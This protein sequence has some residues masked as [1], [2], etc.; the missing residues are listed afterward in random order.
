MGLTT[1]HNAWGGA[2]SVFNDWRK[3]IAHA[4]GLPPL[5]LMEGFYAADDLTVQ[6]LDRGE[7]RHRAPLSARLPIKWEC[8]SPRPILALLNHSD[9][10]GEL[11]ARDLV[12]IAIEL[13][14]LLP[15]L[16]AA[17]WQRETQQFIAGLLAADAGGENLTFQ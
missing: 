12:H 2:Y 9:C 7:Q 15:A 11:L 1:S 4:A 6:R 8:L 16:T 10:E 3:A 14:K 17:G 13:E 5:E